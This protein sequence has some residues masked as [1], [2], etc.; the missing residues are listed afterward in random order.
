VIHSFYRMLTSANAEPKP[1]Q[2]GCADCKCK[3]YNPKPSGHLDLDYIEADP[4]PMATMQAKF[5][6]DY[7]VS[8]WDKFCSLNPS[9]PECLIYE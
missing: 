9:E 1:C 2:G 4:S 3:Q 7:K 8:Y 6:E 5:L